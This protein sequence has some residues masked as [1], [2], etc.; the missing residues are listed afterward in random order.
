MVSVRTIC[1]ICFNPC[2]S[3]SCSRIWVCIWDSLRREVVSI[4]VLV[5]LARESDLRQWGLPRVA[6]SILVLVDLAREFLPDP[7]GACKIPV[8]ILVLVDLARESSDLSRCKRTQVSILVLVDLAREWLLSG[9]NTQTVTGFN[10]CFS[11]SCSR[12]LW[13]PDRCCR[14]HGV[15]FQSLF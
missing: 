5:D 11:G 14:R 3:G 12:I 6:V 13:P 2:F 15:E 9:R 8:S 10:P 1:I 7:H 4:L